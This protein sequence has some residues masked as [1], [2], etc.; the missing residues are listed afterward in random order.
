MTRCVKSV[1]PVLGRAVVFNTSLDSFHGQPTPLACPEGRDRRSIA[2]YY[3][4]SVGNPSSV[5]YRTTT[6]QARPGTVDKPDRKVQ[7]DHLIKDWVPPRL[8]KIAL[9]CNPFK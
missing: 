7:I 3:Y 8:Q 5:K 4:T 6:F 9:R 2:T 1:S